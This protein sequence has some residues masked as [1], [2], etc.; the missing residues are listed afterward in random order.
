M[1]K[2]VLIL[3]DNH[4][5][6]DNMEAL[7]IFFLSKKY[8][9]TESPHKELFIPAISQNSYYDLVVVVG[10]REFL[11]NEIEHQ[12]E[13]TVPVIYLDIFGI[14]NL[15]EKKNLFLASGFQ[16]YTKLADYVETL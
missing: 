5:L 2:R 7:P 12:N 15:S 11:V 14:V 4:T 10:D 1:Y 9:I 3:Y 16:A 8:N 6:R 13:F